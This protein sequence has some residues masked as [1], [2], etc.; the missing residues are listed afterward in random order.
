[1][2]VPK[3]HDP[4]DLKE[5]PGVYD[6]GTGAIKTV[7]ANRCIPGV[8]RVIIRSY[9]GRIQDNRIFFRLGS[10]RSREFATLADALAARK[11]HLT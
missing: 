5:R 3:R 8:E 4:H 6:T 11:V 9:C 1:M 7:E 10:D 2:N